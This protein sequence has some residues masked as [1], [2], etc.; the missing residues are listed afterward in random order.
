MTK[1]AMEKVMARMRTKTWQ[2]L[3]VTMEVQQKRKRRRRKRRRRRR[4]K[5]ETIS[6][7]WAVYNVSIGDG[8]DG[9]DDED[10]G[11]NKKKKSPGVEEPKEDILK[12]KRINKNRREREEK[13]YLRLE[14]NL[15]DIQKISSKWTEKTATC[16]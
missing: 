5:K 8:D 12:Q 3:M 10:G 2:I 7:C 13:I 16:T 4:K 9:G 6:R 11:D 1:M 14:T 15:F